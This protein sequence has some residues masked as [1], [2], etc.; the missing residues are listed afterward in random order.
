M[1]LPVWPGT[2]HWE[3]PAAG[4]SPAVCAN[5]PCCLHVRFEFQCRG[6]QEPPEASALIGSCANYYGFLAR[7][8]WQQKSDLFP[9]LS[10]HADQLLLRAAAGRV[11]HSANTLPHGVASFHRDPGH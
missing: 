3:P 9:R 6:R 8:F 7:L 2:G 5:P 1:L 4:L 11:L 10:E